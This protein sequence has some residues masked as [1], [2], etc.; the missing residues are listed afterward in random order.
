MTTWVSNDKLN[1]VTHKHEEIMRYM[2]ANPEIPLYK[3]A[4][5]FGVTQPWLSTLVHSDVFQALF[6]E[7]REEHHTISVLGLAD[8]LNGVAHATL[9][10]LSEMVVESE[11]PDFIAKVAD[12]ALDRLGYGTK[13][14][15]G[16]YI[17]NSKNV[18]VDASTLEKA[19]AAR[20]KLQDIKGSVLDEEAQ[21]LCGSQEPAV[22]GAAEQA[23]L[24]PPEEAAGGSASGPPVREGGS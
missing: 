7:Y 17:D 20:K 22:G 11:N 24:C 4:Q 14:Q 1:H 21:E 9:D 13:A 10:K 16:T 6:T 15:I 2:I 8:K 5:V 3:V 23:L 12:S 19:N 18:T